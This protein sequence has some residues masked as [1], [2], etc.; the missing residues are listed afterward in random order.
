M[1]YPRSVQIRLVGGTARSVPM[2]KDEPTTFP[3]REPARRKPGRKVPVH[4]RRPRVPGPTRAPGSPGSP[5]PPRNP[6]ADKAKKMAKGMIRLGVGQLYGGIFQSAWETLQV[7]NKPAQ[8]PG[9]LGWERSEFQCRMDYNGF[10][11]GPSYCGGQTA[12]GSNPPVTANVG[13]RST[14]YTMK[15]FVLGA[16]PTAINKDAFSFELK[17]RFTNPSNSQAPYSNTYVYNTYGKPLLPSKRIAPAVREDYFAGIFPALIPILG[18]GVMPIAW[19]LNVPRPETPFGWHQVGPKPAPKPQTVNPVKPGT[20]TVLVPGTKPVTRP[21]SSALPRP[22]GKHTKETKVRMGAAMT[23]VWHG[24]GTL[25][26]VGDFATV[27]YENLPKKLK[28]GFYEKHGRQPKPHEKLLWS[29]FNLN[30]LDIGGALHDYI[31]NEIEDRLYALGGKQMG[32]ANRKWNRPIGFEAGGTLTGG[33][34]YIPTTSTLKPDW[35]PSILP[36]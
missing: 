5:P 14:T 30:Q 35:W 22:P 33:G 15:A 28:V 11:K 23:A 34:E 4:P 16:F 24:I 25:T 9:V 13:L 17:Q 7:F 27:L 1:K 19:P 26:E 10:A 31:A 29:Y 3:R 21:N 18:P 32:K 36:W 20:T 8:D 12:D 2:P 6:L